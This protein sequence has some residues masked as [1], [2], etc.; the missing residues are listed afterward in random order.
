MDARGR[1]TIRRALLSCT[2]C[3]LHASATRPVPWSGPA[4]ASPP[5]RVLVLGEA[6]GAQEDSAGQPFIGPAGRLLR[7]LLS[8]ASIPPDTLTYANAVSCFPR[9]TPNGDELLACAPNLINQFLAIAP[10]YILLVG[11][12]ALSTLRPGLR[13]SAARGNPFAVNLGP[14]ITPPP[15]AF[16]IYHPAAALRER[17]LIPAISTDL[18]TFHRVLTADPPPLAWTHGRDTCAWCPIELDSLTPTGVP[19]CQ[20][21]TK[22]AALSERRAADAQDR[23]RRQRGTVTQLCLGP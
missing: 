18:A 9:R 1:V 21:H 20:A 8:D 5:H 17:D 16:A 2:R 3:P 19:Y 13:I 12:V 11:A 7:R 10:R 15:L 23:L 14:D 6:P 22:V 4:P